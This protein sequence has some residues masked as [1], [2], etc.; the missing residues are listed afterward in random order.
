MQ[1]QDIYKELEENEVIQGLV[2]QCQ[3]GQL[4]KKG[5][6][7]I[8]EKLFYKGRLVLPRES[9]HIPLILQEY[10]DGVQGGTFRSIEDS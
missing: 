10:H 3:A 4:T 7:V 1:I 6:A 2:A 9:K 5:Y 8:Q